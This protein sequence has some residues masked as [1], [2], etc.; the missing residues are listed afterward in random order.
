MAVGS[1]GRSRQ[2]VAFRHSGCRRFAF[3]TVGGG[4]VTVLARLGQSSKLALQE[5]LANYHE[6][7]RL[8]GADPE[9]KVGREADGAAG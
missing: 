3:K 6:L 8:L 5:Q 9:Y 7:C 2:A 4:T 1:D